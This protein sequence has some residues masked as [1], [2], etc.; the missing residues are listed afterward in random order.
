[1]TSPARLARTIV[2]TTA[3]Q[4]LEALIAQLPS[5][6][7]ALAF[8]RGDDGLVG[9]GE[10]ARLEVSGAGRFEAARTWWQD[11][12]AGWDVEDDLAVPGSG[13]VVFGSFSFDEDAVS[14]LVVPQVVLGRRDGAS[15]LTTVDGTGPTVH[16]EPVRRPDGLRYSA[17]RTSVTAW[18]QVV[19]EAVRRIRA[20]SLAKVV[21]A[22]DLVAAAESDIDARYVLAGLAQRYPDC[23]AF[24]VEDLVGA[25]PELLLRRT[26]DRVVSRVL[27]GTTGRGADVAADKAGLA[28]LLSSPKEREEHR[29]AVESVAAALEPFTRLLSVPSEPYVLELPNVAHLASDVSGVL[30]RPADAFELVGALHPTAA[31]GGTPTDAAVRL[32]AELETADRGRYSGPVGW[33]DACGDGEWGIALRCAQL[34]GRTA[35]LFAGC[36]IVADSDADAEVAETL[37]KFVPV[38]DALEGVRGVRGERSRATSSINWN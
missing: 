11:L 22:Y 38:R 17:G 16:P 12:V 32:I 30:D 15:W 8:V 24:A 21:L 5:S 35:R 28:A 34:T 2:R 10:A 37:T 26:G 25:T 13:P 27:A 9:W 3:V 6:S 31:V 7:G 29:Y 14:V 19:E 18:H 33:V 4:P 23:W 20:G 1:M 36:G